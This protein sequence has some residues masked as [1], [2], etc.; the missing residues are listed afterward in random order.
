MVIPQGIAYATLAQLPPEYGLY[1]AFLG[2]I[3][4]TIFGTSKD[5]S[6]GPTAVISLLTGQ[7]VASMSGS[8]FRPETIA[9]A[10]AFLSGIINLF[11]R[12]VNLTIIIEFISIP[13]IIGFTSGSSVSIIAGQL[14]SLMGIKGVKTTDPTINILIS[15]FRKIKTARYQDIIFGVSTLIFLLI[16]KK[17]SSTLAKKNKRYYYIGVVKNALAIIL[18]TSISYG[19][20]KSK[21]SYVLSVVGTVKSG[22][23]SPRLPEISSE[24][25][26]KLIVKAITVTVVVILEHVAIAKALARIDH[27]EINSNSEVL[28]QGIVNVISSFFGAYASTGSFSRSSVNRTSGSQT[29]FNGVWTTVVV[30]ISIL[31]LS[32]A[33][34]YIPRATMSGIIMLSVFELISSPKSVINLWKIGPIDSISTVVAF[35]ATFFFGVEIGIYSAA[36]VSVLSVV[37]K[38]AL[39]KISLLSDSKSSKVYTDVSIFDVSIPSSGIVV[40]RPED[41]IIFLNASHIKHKITDIVSSITVYPENVE[42]EGNGFFISSNSFESFKKKRLEYLNTIFRHRKFYNINKTINNNDDSRY[43][44]E[45]NKKNEDLPI[46]KALVVDMSAVS[47]IDATGIQAL[48]DV[49]EELADYSK[50]QVK[51]FENLNKSNNSTSS[52]NTIAY[53]EFEIH[54]ANVSPS[55]LRVMEISGITGPTISYRNKNSSL[56]LQSLENS[57]SGSSKNLDAI[58][59]SKPYN[60]ATNLMFPMN[61]QT[62]PEDLNKYSFVSDNVHRS[63]KDAIT[64]IY[65][66]RV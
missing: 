28:S 4:Y 5:I 62:A 11:M 55:V 65:N 9:I 14:P 48:I 23:Y 59:I 61:E 49:K 57:P 24:L 40:I 52:A 56:N 44:D 60:I 38:S 15:V 36:G 51:F 7:A 66:N 19:L 10:L 29:P 37:L 6:L 54:Y 30:A 58:A 1:T 42:S 47:T 13:V 16:L 21:S 27:Y 53:S 20:A 17:T 39:P 3:L 41:S 22:F 34:F 32:K 50:K 18:F 2:P 8:G 45:L 33:F 31:F 43:N 64:S 26:S 25:F 63:I 46:L 35:L 12:I